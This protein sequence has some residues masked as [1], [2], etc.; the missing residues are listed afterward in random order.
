MFGTFIHDSYDLENIKKLRDAIEDISSSKDVWGWASCGIYF[1]RAIDTHEI[2]YIGL[3]G[4]LSERFSQHNGLLPAPPNGCKFDLIMDHLNTH[5]RIGIT[6]FTQSPIEQSRVAA[7]KRAEFLVDEPGGID[8]IKFTEGYFIKL[9]ELLNGKLPK[10]NKVQGSIAGQKLAMDRTGSYLLECVNPNMISPFTSKYTITELAS[11][12]GIRWTID[13]V[14]MH[15]IR[16]VALNFPGFTLP[17]AIDF[18]RNSH[19]YSEE[20]YQRLLKNGYFDFLNDPKFHGD[21]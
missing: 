12:E 10:W 2:L 20:R 19:E 21:F 6:I 7:N 17:S 11:K 18:F 14:D 9:Y 13:E 1:Y 15:A 8:R 4:N 3:A 5:G 16:M